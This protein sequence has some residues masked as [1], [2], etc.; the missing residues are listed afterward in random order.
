MHDGHEH[1]HDER[2]E[3]EQKAVDAEADDA[4]R[5]RLTTALVKVCFLCI[6]CSKDLTPQSASYHKGTAAPLSVQSVQA[7]AGMH[8]SA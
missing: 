3:T 7:L 1:V 6:Q 5:S 2:R 8:S 4:E